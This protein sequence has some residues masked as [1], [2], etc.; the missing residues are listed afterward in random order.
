MAEDAVAMA[1][2]GQASNKVE[3]CPFCQFEIMNPKLNAMTLEQVLA[4]SQELIDNAIA[5][6][7]FSPEFLDIVVFPAC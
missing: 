3:I 5:D 7:N 1:E 6:K 2:S 4:Q